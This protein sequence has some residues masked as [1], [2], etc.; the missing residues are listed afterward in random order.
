MAEIPIS[1]FNAYDLQPDPYAKQKFDPEEVVFY[2]EARFR[3]ALQQMLDATSEDRRRMFL[4][5]F[6]E[7]VLYI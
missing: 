2:F 7:M 3:S 1:L 5:L 4:L 6:Y